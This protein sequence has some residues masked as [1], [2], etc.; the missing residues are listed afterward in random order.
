ALPIFRWDTGC[1]G[2]YNDSVV[3]GSVWITQRSISMDN[4]DAIRVACALQVFPCEPDQTLDSLNGVD[5][6]IRSDR[7]SDRRRM[8]SATSADL[9]YFLSWHQFQGLV[10]YCDHVSPV[11]LDV[12]RAYRL[13]LVCG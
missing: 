8:V 9:Q 1:R 10:H 13:A 7:L 12:W 2:C 6:I 11:L 4:D 3:T 5:S